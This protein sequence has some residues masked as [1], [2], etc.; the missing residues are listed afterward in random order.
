M[1]EG[2]RCFWQKE[3][4]RPYIRHRVR[5]RHR[6]SCPDGIRAPSRPH[7]PRS[8]GS[9]G[10]WVNQVFR[11]A[12]R[13]FH[14][15]TVRFTLR[16]SWCSVLGTRSWRPQGR[17]SSRRRRRLV[18]LKRWASGSSRRIVGLAGAHDGIGHPRDLVGHRHDGDIGLTAVLQ[19]RGPAA[20]GV[21]LALDP[22]QD[23][24]CP[25][26]QQLAQIDVTAFTDAE[27]ALAPAGGMLARDQP[28]QAARPRPLRNRPTPRRRRPPGRWRTGR[29]C[30]GSSSAVASCVVALGDGLYLRVVVRDL[31]VEMA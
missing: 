5:C 19:G 26:D 27:Q 30:R 10:L 14:A 22:A 6:P 4:L 20:G 25:M 8:L 11:K 7:H 13:A 1:Q 3:P 15:I 23:G 16:N 29:R 18:G 24:A 21:L 9:A 31:L 12:G 17:R 2:N 28:S